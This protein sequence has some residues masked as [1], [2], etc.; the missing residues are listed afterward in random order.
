MDS[1]HNTNDS[2]Q[3]GKAPASN[4]P[5]SNAKSPASSSKEDESS[6]SS[7]VLASASAL[8]KDLTAPGS[9]ITSQLSNVTSSGKGSSSSQGLNQRSEASGLHEST[10]HSTTGDIGAAYKGGDFRS[11]PTETQWSNDEFEQFMAGEGPVFDPNQTTTGVSQAQDWIQ[12]FHGKAPAHGL[13]TTHTEPTALGS[14]FYQSEYHD[15]DKYDDGAEVR[16]LL[17]DPD[18]V[19]DT[20][21]Y[22]FEDPTLHA[23]AS[24]FS[25]DFS[26]SEQEAVTKI[27]AD[28]PPP[29]SYGS[30][31]NTKQASLP[32]FAQTDASFEE[33]EQAFAK[34]P[35][36]RAE[37]L[38]TWSSA[39]D[40]YVDD[41][42]GAELLPVVQQAR[43]DIEKAKN[44]GA[45]LLDRKALARLKMVLGHVSEQH[46]LQHMSHQTNLP[47]SG[48]ETGGPGKTTAMEDY[49]AQL[50]A[51]ELQ[52]KTIIEDKMERS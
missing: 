22:D 7:R 49:R 23:A 2:Q 28:L 44:D 33:Q 9:H 37:I 19:A 8:A 15:L 25:Q 34:S 42:W 45:G 12:D 46:K 32:F 13:A 47:T 26:P 29:P 6:L 18:F 20:D 51:L 38:E 50:N 11:V 21:V 48:P 10:F 43:D 24:L 16:A 31:S 3:K 14:E 41:V 35:E 52:N 39:I 40:S 4:E 36:L 17:D 30:S 5:V 27:K 1:E